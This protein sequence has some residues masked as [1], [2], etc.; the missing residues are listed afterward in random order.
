MTLMLAGLSLPA[1]GE[2]HASEAEPVVYPCEDG[3]EFEPEMEWQCVDMYIDRTAYGKFAPE[4]RPGEFYGEVP[5]GLKVEP[6][7]FVRNVKYL[8]KMSGIGARDTRV[9]EESE[10]LDGDILHRFGGIVTQGIAWEATGEAKEF[11]GLFRSGGEHGF[12]RY[13]TTQ[14]P[15]LP[16]TSMPVAIAI[17]IFRKKA[18]SGN[19]HFVSTIGD[20]SPLTTHPPSIFK[21][22]KEL[23]F[24]EQLTAAAFERASWS[25]WPS[26]AGTSRFAKWSSDGVL[27]EKTI[28]PFEVVIV[29]TSGEAAPKLASTLE[30]KLGNLGDSGSAWFNSLQ[31]LPSKGVLFKV[32]AISMPHLNETSCVT[33]LNGLSRDV[34]TNSECGW[35]HVGTIHAKG[36]PR[37]S[38]YGDEIMHFA[39]TRFEEDLSHIYGR[40][41]KVFL[42]LNRAKL[43]RT[44]SLQAA[45]F[46]IMFEAATYVEKL[47]AKVGG[48]LNRSPMI[49][50]ILVYLAS[51]HT[52]RF[53]DEKESESTTSSSGTNTNDDD[54]NNNN[55]HP[56]LSDSAET[57]TEGDC[58][59]LNAMNKQKLAEQAQQ[60]N[61]ESQQQQAAGANSVKSEL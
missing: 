50:R 4:E 10:A 12:V 22:D 51:W 25:N 58:P 57:Y 5:R 7:N 9:F 38:R 55:P 33:S 29:P 16:G 39:R 44:S 34:L 27:E 3:H 49:Q 19:L 18:P 2:M 30:K 36:P 41:W 37:A 13:A 48:Y 20:D 54:N 11:T 42:D 14:T 40:K 32:Y 24:E 61:S 23:T 1:C 59:Y 31:T 47:V 53:G 56:W 26:Y 8:D 6:T 15:G 43:V 52:W 28:F 21:I 35:K 60:Q 17:K 46:Q 45:G